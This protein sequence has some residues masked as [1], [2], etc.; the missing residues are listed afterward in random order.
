MNNQ[1]A[2]DIVCKH[3][4]SMKHQSGIVEEDGT[5]SC[6]YR[7]D[8]GNMC[9]VGVLIPDD[10][11]SNEF[12]GTSITQLIQRKEVENIFKG[13]DIGLLCKFQTVHDDGTNWDSNGLKPEAIDTLCKIGKHYRLDV[14]VLATKK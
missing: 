5:I 13:C 9:A 3:L 8:R 7:D 6:Q 12:E 11:Y 1:Q 2:F 14:G 10:V 4:L